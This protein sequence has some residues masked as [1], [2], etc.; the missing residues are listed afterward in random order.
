[1]LKLLGPVVCGAH[2]GGVLQLGPSSS[3]GA[4][5]AGGSSS[6][7]E[8]RRQGMGSGVVCWAVELFDACLDL[9]L[10]CVEEKDAVQW[11]VARIERW[12]SAEEFL[13]ASAVEV[14]TQESRKFFKTVLM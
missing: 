10:E 8:E 5:E 7:W 14:D 3:R 13:W 6:S 11:P 1:M 9:G 2:D 12:A 4:V